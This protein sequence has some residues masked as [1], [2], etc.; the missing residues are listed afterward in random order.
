MISNYLLTTPT[1]N[2]IPQVEELSL[3]QRIEK[4]LHNFDKLAQSRVES[5]NEIVKL[6]IMEKKE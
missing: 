5:G 6:E 3:T 2:L 4:I 1:R